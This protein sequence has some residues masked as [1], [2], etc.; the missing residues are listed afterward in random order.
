MAAKVPKYK[1][2]PG[3]KTYAN[4]Y[5]FRLVKP[6]AKDKFYLTLNQAKA[7]MRKEVEK[8]QELWRRMGC[9]EDMTACSKVLE[10]IGHLDED[11][12]LV[13][14]YLDGPKTVRYSV[15]VIPMTPNDKTTTTPQ[16]E[17]RNR[18]S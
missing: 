7:A 4:G 18:L 14:G 13:V 3:T 6:Y 2:P 16:D 8:Y 9:E 17:D 15:R 5:R 10:R 12:G 1:P 11:G